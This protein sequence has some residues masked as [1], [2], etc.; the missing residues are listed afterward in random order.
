MCIRDRVTPEQLKA[1]RNLSYANL[2]HAILSLYIDDIPSE[3]LEAIC[4]KTYSA[5]VFCNM[6]P[7]HSPYY[8]IDGTAADITPLT[9]SLIHI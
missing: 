5:E 8:P 9:L 4:H 6:D 2:A 1:W 3:D 7:T